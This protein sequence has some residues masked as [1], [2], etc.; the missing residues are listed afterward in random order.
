MKFD[1]IMETS[2]GRSRT[3]HE[4]IMID[5]SKI[6]KDNTEIPLDE[7]V[8][9]KDTDNDEQP[10]NI[11][12]S[13]MAVLEESIRELGQLTPAT[14]RLLDNGKYELLSGHKRFIAMSRLGAEALLCR[15]CRFTDKEAFKAVCHGNIQRKGEK[16][17][18]LCRMYNGYRKRFGEE[19]SI[20]EI[21]EFFGVSVK[22]LYR[23]THINYLIDEL[24]SYVDSNLLS[25]HAVEL[26]DKLT[27]AQQKVIAEYITQSGKAI[28]P[29]KAKKLITLATQNPDFTVRD[30]DLLLSSATDRSDKLFKNDLYNT[31][32]LHNPSVVGNM[33]EA[34]LDKLVITLLDNYFKEQEPKKSSTESKIWDGKTY[35]KEIYKILST[36]EFKRI[37]IMAYVDNSESL[38]DVVLAVRDQYKETGFSDPKASFEYWG[39][40][41]GLIITLK[42]KTG[43]S[44]KLMWKQVTEVLVDLAAT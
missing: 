10:F 8:L 28:S 41:T 6:I 19:E 9:F 43:A 25:M 2:Q 24:K 33:K 18:E 23:C 35:K 29:A 36:N 32:L 1:K 13:E 37:D 20:T 31:V 15:V 34:E 3:R 16:P 22:T 42:N 30:A 12:E 7:I 4:D 21:S 39:M 5:N 44:I 17:T 27:L 26:V 11:D 14:V 40:P 38:A